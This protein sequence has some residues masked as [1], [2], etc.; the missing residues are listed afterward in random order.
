MKNKSNRKRCIGCK[1]LTHAKY[2]VCKKCSYSGK[3]WRKEE[4]EYQQK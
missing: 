3:Y 2:Q 1:K 4:Y